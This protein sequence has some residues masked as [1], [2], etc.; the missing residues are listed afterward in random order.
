[1][2]ATASAPAAV[3]PLSDAA[4]A[5]PGAGP[6]GVAGAGGAVEPVPAAGPDGD[7]DT[8]PP[9][10]GEVADAG[11]LVEPGAGGRVAVAVGAAVGAAVA[12]ASAGGQLPDG[13]SGGEGGRWF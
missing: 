13:P 1:M 9:G 4:P 12:G 3:A 7:D 6:L 5:V 10:G 11:A 2:A 8:G